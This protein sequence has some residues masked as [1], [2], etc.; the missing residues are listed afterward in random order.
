MDKHFIK[1]QHLLLLPFLSFFLCLSV[2]LGASIR[3]AAPTRRLPCGPVPCTAWRRALILAEQR[4][5][6]LGAPGTF[7]GGLGGGGINEEAISS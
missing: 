7:F 2:N 5:W 3:S 6:C 1:F 4:F